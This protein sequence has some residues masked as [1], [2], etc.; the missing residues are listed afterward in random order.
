MRN[1][2]AIFLLVLCPSC[3]PAKTICQELP[4]EI[5]E[6]EFKK[7]MEEMVKRGEAEPWDYKQ[8][9]NI[10]CHIEPENG[11]VADKKTAELVAEA[12]MKGYFRDR[13]YLKGDIFEAEQLPNGNWR[14]QA[15]NPAPGWRQRVPT[16][17]ISRKDA[18]VIRF[19]ID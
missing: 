19:W 10:Q 11:F 7:E 3:L 8:P 14:V 15:Y 6:Q 17:E 13:P 4:T 18:K 2:L 16:I 1:I 12:L 9:K 5:S